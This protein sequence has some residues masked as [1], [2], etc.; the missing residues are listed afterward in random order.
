VTAFR[1]L[2]RR[3]RWLVVTLGALGALGAAGVAIVVLAAPWDHSTGRSG[4]VRVDRATLRSGQVVF[5]VVN[6][7]EETARIAQVI[8]NDAFVDFRQSQHL[9]SPGDAEQ[10]TVSYPWIRGESYEIQLMTATGPTV[11]YE[12]DEAEAGTRSVPA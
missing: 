6:D 8:F 3:R 4:D 7:S 11:D 10:I 2:L 5:V 1:R 12:L 9:L